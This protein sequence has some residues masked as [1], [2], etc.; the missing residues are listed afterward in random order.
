M[1]QVRK[2]SHCERLRQGWTEKR[3]ARGGN[4]GRRQAGLSRDGTEM[5]REGLKQKWRHAVINTGLKS[6]HCWEEHGP[7]SLISLSVWARQK[8]TVKNQKSLS[9]CFQEIFNA[10]NSPGLFNT[11]TFNYGRTI[12]AA[13]SFIVP[14]SRLHPHTSFYLPSVQA[15]DQNSTPPATHSR[16]FSRISVSGVTQL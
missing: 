13:F 15:G 2:L 5:K 8:H 9:V 11:N 10:I 3:Q 1:A 14:P 6:G 7:L 4:E 12:S 16:L